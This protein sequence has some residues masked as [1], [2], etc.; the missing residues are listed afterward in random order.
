MRRFAAA[1]VLLFG[2]CVSQAMAEDII[3]YTAVTSEVAADGSRIVQVPPRDQTRRRRMLIDF[4]LF[5]AGIHVGWLK[6]RNMD[7]QAEGDAAPRRFA[8]GTPI[9][10]VSAGTHAFG[11]GTR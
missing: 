1:V 5:G 11:L 10:N 2:V 4:G 7:L 3:N 6:P 9:F 8:V